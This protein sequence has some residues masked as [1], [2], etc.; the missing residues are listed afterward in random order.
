M[1]LGQRLVRQGI[2]IVNGGR[3]REVDHY[4]FA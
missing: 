4:I 1:R 3:S 2:A